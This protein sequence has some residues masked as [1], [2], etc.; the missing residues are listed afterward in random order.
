[1]FE[2]RSNQVYDYFRKHVPGTIVRR[3][4]GAFYFCVVFEDGVLND[5]QTLPIRNTDV[6]AY[7]KQSVQGVPLDKRFV[8]YMMASAGVCVTPLSGFHTDIPGFRLTTLAPDDVARAQTL[9]RIGDSI[10]RYIG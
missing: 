10:R 7:V 5:R 1:M 6:R 3:T 2:H 9:T 8:H 4:Q